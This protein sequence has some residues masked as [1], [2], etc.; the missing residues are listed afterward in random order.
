MKRTIKGFSLIELMIVVAIIGILASIAIPAYSTYT[1]KA[2][3][4]ELMSYGGGL[5]TQVAAFLQ[6]NAITSIAAGT[7]A[8]T[9]TPPLPSSLA[10]GTPNT[11]ITASWNVSGTASCVISVVS[12]AIFPAVTGVT[13]GGVMTMKF[14]PTMQGDGSIS[15]VCSSS[16]SQYAPSTCQ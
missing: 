13:P 5:T 9:A 12:K 8:T 2:K 7:C 16:G 10:S 3:A 4:S 15:W 1:Y 11:A 6:E 14:T